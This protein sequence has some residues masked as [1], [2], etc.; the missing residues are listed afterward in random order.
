MLDSQYN[1]V[2]LS[3]LSG[4]KIKII[5]AFHSVKDDEAFV[6]KNSKLLTIF[7]KLLHHTLHC[8]LDMPQTLF[9]R[10][11]LEPSQISMMELFCKIS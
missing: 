5:S 8:I 3:L 2:D 4:F 9:P 10:A 6:K 11:Y 1:I 7:V